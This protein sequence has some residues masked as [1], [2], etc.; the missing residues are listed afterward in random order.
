M[1]RNPHA[2]WRQPKPVPLHPWPFAPHKEHP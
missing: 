1:T 2:R